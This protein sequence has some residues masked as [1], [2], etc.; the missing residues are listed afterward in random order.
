M[1]WRLRRRP[2]PVTLTRFAARSCRVGG[3]AVGVGL[4]VAFCVGFGGL[5]LLGPFVRREH[6]H[7][8]AAVEAALGLDP[9]RPV[10]LLGDLV[11]DPLAEF[12]VEHFAASEH[13]RDLHLVSLVEEPQDLTGLGVEVALADLGA[14][15][16]LLDA[17]AGGLA[18]GLLGPLRR[19]EFELAVVHDAAHR[20][21]GL[22]GHL[23]EVEI[24]LPGD[25]QRLREGF[26]AQL[27]AV[28][29]HQ[30]HLTGTD[31]V[32]DTRFAGGARS[33]DAA[34]LLARP[35]PVA[36][37]PTRKALPPTVHPSR[38]RSGPGRTLGGRVGVLLSPTPLSSVT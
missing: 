18:P 29:C 31:L 33:G 4:S 25:R 32:V 35:R 1:A 22:G 13:D 30:A 23:D 21:I 27:L 15:L 9:S 36:R 7:H 12:G 6:H 19:I 34:S 37:S 17:H 26:D 28:G 8:V 38:I 2:V 3:G 16:H 11:Q 24:R 14:V 20:R 10:G 5:G